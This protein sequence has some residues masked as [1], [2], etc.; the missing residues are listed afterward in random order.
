MLTHTLTNICAL[1]QKPS[2]Y[3]H[4]FQLLLSV[5]Y[6]CECLFNIQVLTTG[7][8]DNNAALKLVNKTIETTDDWE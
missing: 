7:L 8:Y 4:D 1:K 5:S 6:S 3:K 2:K